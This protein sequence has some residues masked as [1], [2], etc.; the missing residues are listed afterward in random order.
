MLKNRHCS[1]MKGDLF[2]SI[3]RVELCIKNVSMYVIDATHVLKR[4]TAH[5]HMPITKYMCMN[6]LI[7]VML[8]LVSVINIQVRVIKLWERF[9]KV[10]PKTVLT[11]CTLSHTLISGSFILEVEIHD[12][13][14]VSVCLN[15]NGSYG[16][17][18]VM[19]HAT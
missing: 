15:V 10:F 11:R 8:R 6:L 4:H 16:R 2:I 3:L 12:T 17:G 9:Y 1:D 19:P 7:D 14:H 5:S 18:E 13:W